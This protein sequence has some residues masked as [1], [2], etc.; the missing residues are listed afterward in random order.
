[1]KILTV[2]DYQRVRLPGHVKPR[3]KLA[4][5]RTG[6]RIVL[7]PIAPVEPRAGKVRLVKRRGFTVGVLN[8]PI[9]E[10]ALAEALAEFP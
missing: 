6:N 4:Y 10:T 9:N 2:D 8:R 5:E 7:T 1:M 3:T